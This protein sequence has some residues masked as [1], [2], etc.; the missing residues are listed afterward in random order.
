MDAEGLTDADGDREADGDTDADGDME[1]LEA[2]A[3]SI[4]SFAAFE[5]VLS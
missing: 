5:G 4:S 2:P 3:N 1:A